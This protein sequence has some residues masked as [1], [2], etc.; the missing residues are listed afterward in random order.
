MPAWLAEA[1]ERRQV[2]DPL[3]DDQPRPSPC[4]SPDARLLSIPKLKQL[5]I[6][7]C[8][9]DVLGLSSPSQYE[10]IL[11]S[12]YDHVNKEELPCRLEARDQRDAKRFGLVWQA[13]EIDRDQAL[14]HDFVALD[15]VPNTKP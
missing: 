7:D 2:S 1:A 11:S 14:N 4:P 10:K 3:G 8:R 12:R 15:L 6:R 5:K 13:N 9:S